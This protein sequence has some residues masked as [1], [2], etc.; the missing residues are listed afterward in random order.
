MNTE[1]VP[2]AHPGDKRLC[3]LVN[4]V[5]SL[6]YNSDVFLLFVFFYALN[7]LSLTLTSLGQ[8]CHLVCPPVTPDLRPALTMGAS[9][10]RRSC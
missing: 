9:P 8:H 5:L 6:V 3:L 7:K 4:C 10:E 1:F 2:A